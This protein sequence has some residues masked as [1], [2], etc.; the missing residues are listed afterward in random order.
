MLQV[1][2]SAIESRRETLSVYRS[3][4]EILD[5]GG[6]FAVFGCLHGLRRK[7]IPRRHDYSWN[8]R[9][10]DSKSLVF[11][12]VG[13]GRVYPET[14]YEQSCVPR[15]RFEYQSSKKAARS[16]RRF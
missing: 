3:T 16:R 7:R 9:G 15:E 2:D 1:V 4:F 6:G 14:I 8:E 10:A 5:T 11:M 12:K 13:C